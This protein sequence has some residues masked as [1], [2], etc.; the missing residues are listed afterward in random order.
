MYD[1]IIIG[2]GQ[3]GCEAAVKL[4]EAGYNVVIVDNG[5]LPEAQ[6]WAQRQGVVIKEQTIVGKISF[7]QRCQL[8][9]LKKGKEL[10]PDRVM[11]SL[12]IIIAI[13]SNANIDGL[14][15]LPRP[16][17]FMAGGVITPMMCQAA[18]DSG[19]KAAEE[20]IEWLKTYPTL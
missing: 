16:G 13:G 5:G 17:V 10:Q 1:T 9:Y 20:A 14:Q 15:N 3:A 19:I 4:N 2:G 7:G 6:K 8:V 18:A 12:S 11:G